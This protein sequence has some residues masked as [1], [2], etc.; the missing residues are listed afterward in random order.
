[1]VWDDFGAHSNKAATQHDK[2][3]DEFKGGFDVLGTQIAVLICTLVDPT[4]PTYQLVNKFTAEV[5]ILDRGLYKY[6]RC[7]WKQ[8]FHSWRIR[9]QKIFV[10]KNTFPEWPTEVYQ[11]YNVQRESLVPEVFQRIEDASS[12]SLVANYVKLCQPLDAEILEIMR[13]RGE[14]ESHML[15]S[16]GEEGKRAMT[17]LKSRGLALSNKRGVTYYKADITPLGLSVL[18]TYREQ[19]EREKGVE[20]A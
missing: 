11:E 6:D 7:Q 1:M 19:Q 14:I 2:G 5:Q 3:W 16:Y 17:R 20:H 18:K 10:E 8:D 15:D 13:T 12:E 4:E 9:V